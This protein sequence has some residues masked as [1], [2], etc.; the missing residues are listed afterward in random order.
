MTR[1]DR[2]S[3]EPG[4][5]SVPIRFFPIFTCYP[6]VFRLTILGFAVFDGGPRRG[7]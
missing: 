7:P 6:Q 1:F 3:R 4:K 2:Q 5:E